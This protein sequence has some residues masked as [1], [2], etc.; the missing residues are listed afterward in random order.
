LE[1]AERLLDLV[2]LLLDAREPLPFARL[3]DLFPSEY[4]GST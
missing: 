3:R 4:G 1:K 2:A